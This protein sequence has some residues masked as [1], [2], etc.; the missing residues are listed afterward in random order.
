MKKKITRHVIIAA[1]ALA[2]LYA[3]F[4]FGFRVGCVH[5]IKEAEYWTVEVFD[6]ADP[7]ASFWQGYD[8]QI[9]VDLDGETYERGL[10]QY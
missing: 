9:F 4:S 2:L 6:P 1:L 5:A 7:A 3:I 8:L 10:M